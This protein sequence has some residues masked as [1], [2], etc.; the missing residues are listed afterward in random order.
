MK[1]ISVQNLDPATFVVSDMPGRPIF[2][3]NTIIWRKY[4]I[5]RAQKQ[6]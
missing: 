4:F 2:N 6:V 5:D 1:P 3:P